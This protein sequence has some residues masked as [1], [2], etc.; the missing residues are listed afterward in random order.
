MLTRTPRALVAAAALALFAGAC[1]DAPTTPAAARAEGG[2]AWLSTGSG[3][4]LVSTAIKYRDTGGKPARGRSGSAELEATALLRKN[5]ITTVDLVSRHVTQSGLYGEITSA[6]VKASDAGGKHKFTR[7]VNAADSGFH[8][9]N[10]PISRAYLPGLVRGDQLQLQAHVRGLDGNRTDVVT[11]A[12]TVKRIPDLRVRMDAPAE[13]ETSTWVNILAVVSENN[14]DVGAYAVC[15][16][17]VAGEQVDIAE[18]VWVDAGDAV[19]C[20]MTWQFSLAGTYPLEVRVRT[21]GAPSEDWEPADNADTATIQVNGASAR[22]YTSGYFSASTNMDSTVSQ[23]SW[24]DTQLGRSGESG[25]EWYNRSSSVNAS[26]YGYLPLQVTGPADLRVSMTT[27]AH[28]V[29]AAEWTQLGAD[30]PWGWCAD[31]F[32]GQTMFYM[33]ANGGGTSFSYAFMAGEVTYHSREYSRVWDNLSGTGSVYHRNDGYTSGT[34][35]PVADDW[36]F[37]VRVS[38]PDG[39]FDGSKS[40]PLVRTTQEFASPYQCETYEYPWWGYTYTSC[41]TS[42]Y[43]Y[44]SV[45]GS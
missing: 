1:T 28:V 14:G 30:S 45:Y 12:E 10:P 4:T 5:G 38:S 7:M 24:R 6:L 22:F 33:C 31:T 32:D 27:G 39:E 2:R 44:E 20:A 3:P 36:S 21:A 9:A 13:V 18:G 17:Y 8:Q 19:T 42:I 40:L 26:A 34:A 29:H 25:N 37:N 43:R 11:V 16:L 15:E 23:V 35:V 41:G